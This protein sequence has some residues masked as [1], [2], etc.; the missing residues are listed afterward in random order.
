MGKILKF[1]PRKKEKS[2]SLKDVTA[3]ELLV[4]YNKAA[5]EE[6]QKNPKRYFGLEA[7]KVPEQP[8]LFACHECGVAV[9]EG[10]E[11]VEGKNVLIKGFPAELHKKAKIRAIE[12]EK[13]FK[14][15]VEDAVRAYLIRGDSKEEE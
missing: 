5:D 14:K 8:F 15:L 6:K 11:E 1:R 2:P 13:T 4:M 9:Y 3:D 7:K 12:E 10:G